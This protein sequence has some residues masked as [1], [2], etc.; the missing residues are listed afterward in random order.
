MEILTKI[1]MSQK[2]L[3]YANT[4]NIAGKKILLADRAKI[5]ADEKMLRIFLLID[6]RIL[7]AIL[8]GEKA[9]P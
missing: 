6:Q 5:E 1:L 8:K 4:T 2:L 7:V 3:H 9:D